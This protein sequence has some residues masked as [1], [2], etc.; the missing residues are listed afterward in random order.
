[1]PEV[2]RVLSK[3]RPFSD[4]VR[5][6]D[7]QGYTGKA[8]GLGILKRSPGGEIVS[9]TEKPAPEI[10]GELEAY[11]APINPLWPRWGLRFFD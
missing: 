9:F 7:W 2:N 4:L 10:L 6:G 3:M 5:S 1:M 11:R 8:P